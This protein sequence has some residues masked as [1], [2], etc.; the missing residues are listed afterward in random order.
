M[1]KITYINLNGNQVIKEFHG[2]FEAVEYIIH[3][4]IKGSKIQ[5]QDGEWEDSDNLISGMKELFS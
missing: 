5:I 4:G 1:T 3:S 2:I